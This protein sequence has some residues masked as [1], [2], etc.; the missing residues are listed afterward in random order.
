M[1]IN[2]FTVRAKFIIHSMPRAGN[3]LG[4]SVG[5]GDIAVNKTESL[6]HITYLLEG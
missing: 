3:V 1:L 2:T 4:T 6:P 5:T